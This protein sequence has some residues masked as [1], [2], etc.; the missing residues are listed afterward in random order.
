MKR[1]QKILYYFRLILFIISL[2]LMFLTLKN[3]IKIGIFGY[4]Y[5]WIEFVYIV[6]IILTFLSKREIY[7]N[8]L[9]FNIMHICTYLYQ[10]IMIIRMSH[11]KVS[12]LIKDSILFYR[13]NY[14]I[15]TV[16]L[17]T[18]IFYN[19]ILYNDLSKNRIK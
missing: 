8:D 1:Y 4:V 14:I 16:L 7:K 9:V 2:I 19:I 10:I 15:L 5:L 13:N 3:Y 17:L 12:I 6:T 18:L 11:Y